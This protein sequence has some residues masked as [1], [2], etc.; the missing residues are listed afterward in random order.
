MGGMV[1][2]LVNQ[3]KLIEITM[4]ARRKI[5]SK[6][7]SNICI[8]MGKKAQKI[9][10]NLKSL[11]LKNDVIDG[12]ID[13]AWK[14]L[15]STV[16]SNSFIET[17]NSVIRTHLDTFNSIPQWF[18]QLFTFYWNNRVF[19]RGKRAGKSPLEI[20]QS[21]KSNSKNWI[22]QIMEKFPFEK[23]RSSISWEQFP[24]AS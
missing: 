23:I 7:A 13:S 10:E 12:A 18:C 1:I 6:A 8:G 15:H 16:K 14:I 24:L 3:T 2:G 22:E 17:V 21:K 20:Y 4:L 9:I 19:P 5:A 11:S